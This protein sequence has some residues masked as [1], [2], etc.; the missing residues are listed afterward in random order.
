MTSICSLAKSA[1]STLAATVLLIF[2]MGH[3]SLHA[4]SI[5]LGNLE[6]TMTRP[7]FHTTGAGLR[8]PTGIDSANDG[9]DIFFMSGLAGRIDMVN[10]GVET[11]FLDL[12]GEVFAGGGTGLLGMAFH[13]GYSDPISPGYRTMYTY[14]STTQNN[15]PVTFSIAG[16]TTTHYNVL[17]EWQASSSNPNVI[18]V[19]TRREL[20]REAH[21]RNNEH[22]GGALDFGPDGYLYVTT[23]AS[24]G[25][26]LKSQTLD[27]ILGKV[28]RIDPIA[29]VLTPS[30]LDAVSANGLYRIPA[31]NPFVSTPSAITEIYAL[32]LRNPYRM[33]IDPVTGLVFTGDVGQ[34]AREEVSVFGAGANLGW[35]YREGS[36]AGPRTP[37]SP[38]PTMVDPIA[39]YSHADGRSITGGFVYRGSTIPELYGKY[40]FGEFS[41]GTGAFGASPGRLFWLDPYDSEGNLRVPS[42]VEIFEFRFSPSTLAIFDSFSID[43]GDN[44]DITLYSF[45]VDNAGEIY[46]CGEEANRLTIYKIVGA[47]N[48]SPPGDFDGDLDVD[49]LDLAKWQGDY[50]INGNSDAD[51]DGDSDGRDFLI[52]QRN[53]GTGVPISSAVSVP[54]PASFVLFSMLACVFARCRGILHG[55]K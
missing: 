26:E 6:V 29:P 48:L 41:Y 23:G 22:N 14:H 36:V 35:P 27:N 13:P 38:I 31:T 9:S 43:I 44:L 17:T 10:A 53:V 55:C 54:E 25:L 11:Q 47:Q 46:V 32:G 28:L 30:S 40:I 24:P 21:P 19:S 50:G 12:T 49:D 8:F 5:R 39:D 37:T 15:G 2:G 52:W 45:G 3:T 51:G 4:Q 20:Y 7:V 33:S 34:A 18:D 42:E 16:E 1:I